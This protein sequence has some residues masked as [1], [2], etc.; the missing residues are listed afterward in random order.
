M[1]DCFD[2]RRI[3]V[4]FS[5]RPAYHDPVARRAWY[6]RGSNYRRTHVPWEYKLSAVQN[7]RVSKKLSLVNKKFFE[8]VEEESVWLQIHLQIRGQGKPIRFRPK[9]DTIC[10]DPASLCCL[11]HFLKGARNGPEMSWR[12]F[13]KI[14]SI[15]TSRQYP[16][17]SDPRVHNGFRE[18]LPTEVLG[19]LSSIAPGIAPPPIPGTAP[20]PTV[21]AARP[22]CILGGLD[23][24]KMMYDLSPPV[25]DN[26]V[27]CELTD[28][29][30]YDLFAC[31]VRT[32][33]TQRAMMEGASELVILR[34][35][36]SSASLKIVAG[37]YKSTFQS[38][39]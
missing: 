9:F 6:S 30:L 22:I 4:K 36:I 12:G 23:V 25:A 31:R 5:M 10:M 13:D 17:P 32:S 39:L 24:S 38:Y 16:C 21:V 26:K 34:L 28:D 15:E 19:T 2:S 7:D 18:I 37:Q 35:G 3:T 29:L 11:N 8:F 1:G 27:I 33:E 20:T 14:E